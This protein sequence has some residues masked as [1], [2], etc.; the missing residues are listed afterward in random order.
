[1][2]GV[3]GSS[4]LWRGALPKRRRVQIAFL[5]PVEPSLPSASPDSVS[6]LIDERVWPAVEEEYGRLSATPGLIAAALAAAGIGGGLLARRRRQ[7][8]TR[9]RQ[10]PGPCR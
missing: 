3:S 4:R 7:T 9:R 8:L 5:L 2:G 6:E 1:V 10:F